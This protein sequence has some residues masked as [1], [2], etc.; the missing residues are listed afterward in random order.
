M[1]H[2]QFINCLLHELDEAGIIVS[3]TFVGEV[4]TSFA[5]QAQQESLL[6]AMGISGLLPFLK[7]SSVSCNVRQFKGK[8]V[9]IDGYCWLHRGAFCCAEK[10]AKGEQTHA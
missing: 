8:T 5:F 4:T 6:F 2:D 10:L 3:V 7:R 9:A 1:R